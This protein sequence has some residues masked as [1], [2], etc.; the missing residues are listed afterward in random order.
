MSLS[1]KLYFFY[2]GTSDDLTDTLLKCAADKGLE[3]RMM[4]GFSSDTTNAM[5]GSFHSVFT[6]LKTAIPLYCYQVLHVS[7]VLVT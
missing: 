7:S 4:V 3:K 2:L 5:A 6:N 1:N